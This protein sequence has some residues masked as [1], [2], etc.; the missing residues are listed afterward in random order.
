MEHGGQPFIRKPLT[1]RKV[2]IVGAG[3]SGLAC[4]HRLALHGH[5]VVLFDKHDLAGG[6]NEYGVAAYKLA[7]DFAQKEV[8]FLFNI[9]GYHLLV[10]KH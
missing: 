1:G 4:A 10:V 5:D 2:A 7:D 9:G 8:D 6:L 3:P